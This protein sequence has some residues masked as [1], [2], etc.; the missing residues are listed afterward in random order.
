VNIPVTKEDFAKIGRRFTSAEIA[1]ETD[2][3]IPMAKADLATLETGGY[4]RDM[5]D[6][7]VGFRDQLR[8]ESAAKSEIRG[9]KKGA[10]LSEGLAFDEGR[11]ALR[12]GISMALI[13]I[14]R[15][16]LPAGEDPRTTQERVTELTHMVQA[17]G[18]RL[19]C[20]PAALRS[21]LE[22]LR[23]LLGQP[24]FAPPQGGAEARQKLVEKLDRAIGLITDHAEA[25]KDL[26]ERSKGKTMSLDELDGRAYTNLRFLSRVGRACFLDAG[27]QVRADGYLLRKLN[28]SK[29]DFNLAP[30]P[31]APAPSPPRPDAPMPAPDPVG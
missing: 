18:G 22:G 16:Q 23:A 8:T 24:D 29:K 14:A 10:R 25:K 6:E 7:L 15:R 26:K 20:D 27:D 9:A 31:E 13:A 28:R 2:R 3:L 21:R 1:N 4:S 12:K 17:L 30:K 5:L 11:L 19:N